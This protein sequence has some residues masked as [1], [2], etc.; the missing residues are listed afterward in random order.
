MKKNAHLKKFCSDKY[1]D[2]G[3]CNLP[4]ARFKQKNSKLAWCLSFC[5]SLHQKSP[6]NNIRCAAQ[7]NIMTI[8]QKSLI[9]LVAV[10]NN[11]EIFTSFDR[12]RFRKHGK[13]MPQLAQGNFESS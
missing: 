13:L 3:E 8:S 5:A 12:K 1:N 6:F 9:A 4:C 10:D 11:V 2:C 7:I